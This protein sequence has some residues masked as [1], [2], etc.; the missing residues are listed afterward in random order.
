MTPELFEPETDTLLDTEELVTSF[1]SDLQL[2]K[3]RLLTH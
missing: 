1:I 3:I 2:I